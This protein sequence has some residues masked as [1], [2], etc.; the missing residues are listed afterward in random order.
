[1]G[2]TLMQ[3]LPKTLP[4]FFW[5]FYKKNPIAFTVFLLAPMVLVLETTTIP[6]GLKIIVD[7]ISQHGFNRQDVFT[8][9]TPALW[10][11]GL[12][13]VSMVIVI[14]LQ[15]WWQ[16]YVIPG[17]QADI[18]LSV[19]DYVSQH[20]YQFFAD[21]FSG[22]LAN[23]VADLA[24]SI[25]SVRMIFSWNIVATMA[26]STAALIMLFHISTL[27]AGILAIWICLHLT[28]T[29]SM[30][31]YINQHSEQNAED[32]SALNGTIVDVLTNIIPVKLFASQRHELHYVR[33]KQ[34]IE[35]ASNKKL[36]L[37][38]NRFRFCMD[39]PV[40]IMLACM[41]YALVTYWKHDYISTGD[42]VFIFNV[43]FTVI[44]QMWNLAHAF[45]ELFQEIG[46]ATQGLKLIGSTHDIVDNPNASALIVK[47]GQIEFDK[48]SF[49]YDKTTQ[50]FQNK[51]VTISPGEKIGLV[52][53]S[54]SGKSTFVNLILRF[55]NLDNGKILIDG[56]DIATVTQSSLRANIA[57][58]PQDTSLF[59]RTIKE[60][61]HYG[62]IDA[63]EQDVLA[64][65]KLAHCHDFISQLPNGYDT[66]VG[67]RGVKLSGGQRQRIS[68]A[69]AILKD[70]PILILDEATAALDSYTEAQIQASLNTLMQNRTTIVIA[71]RLS[72][73][74]KMDRILVF[75]NGKIIEDGDHEALLQAKGHYAKLWD[76]QVRGFLPEQKD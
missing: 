67:E 60:N 63:T 55:Y 14:R 13:W 19:L 10:L 27:F 3:A 68:I 34:N 12:S 22:N 30:A 31:A 21:H 37:A 41:I 6:Y 48:V 20:S 43:T 73:L 72:T 32:I 75:D 76:M 71:H 39:I 64:A 70:A 74:A 1:M 18:R 36:I 23:K 33:E 29:F 25:E 59:H 24:R 11:I 52:G 8:A 69:R 5:H 42:F 17:F 38:M 58:I 65:S 40:T 62:R 35:A 9:L 4:K 28:I 56:Q 61:I 15:N 44:F 46:V 66:L 53:F 57:M 50:V 16:A 2:F 54:G 49:K 7:T 51:S 26:I 45:T 47:Q